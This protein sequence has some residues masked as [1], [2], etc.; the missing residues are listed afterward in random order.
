MFYELGNE[1][2]DQG[3]FEKAIKYYND[4]LESGNNSDKVMY[5]LSICYFE[6]GDYNSSIELANKIISS[7]DK[8]MSNLSLFN[9]GNCFHELKEYKKAEKDF[10][11]I[12]SLFP[13]NSDAYYNRANAREKLNN[14]I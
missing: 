11:K 4:T 12:I 7:D 1:A 8:I 14:S 13:F 3:N 10:S 2:F 5:N 6:I 9:R